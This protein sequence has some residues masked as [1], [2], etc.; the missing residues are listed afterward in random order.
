MRA[1][2]TYL[3]QDFSLR[4]K[5]ADPGKWADIQR[6]DFLVRTRELSAKELAEPVVDSME[7]KEVIAYALM[8]LTGRNA[9]PTAQAWREALAAPEPGIE[10]RAK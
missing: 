1:D 5:V 8:R 3:R 9:A 10:A 2:I 6:F 4:Q 7:Y